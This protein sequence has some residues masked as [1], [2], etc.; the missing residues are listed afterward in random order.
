MFKVAN[1]CCDQCL[2]SDNKIVSDKRKEELLDSIMHEESHFVCHKATINGEDVCCRG[3]FEE[4]GRDVNKIRI[5]ER[6]GCIEYVDVE[7]KEDSK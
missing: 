2:M 4:H 7:P 1:K 6:I 5:F 3:W